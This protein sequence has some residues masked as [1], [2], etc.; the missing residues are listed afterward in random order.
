MS[1]LSI[2]PFKNNQTRPEGLEPSTFGFGD[3]R[4]TNWTKDAY[5]FIITF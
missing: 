2:T 4:S 5:E 3:Q 1:K